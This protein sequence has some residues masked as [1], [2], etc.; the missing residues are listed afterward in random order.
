MALKKIFRGHLSPQ[1]NFLAEILSRK[2]LNSKKEHTLHASIC[3][4]ECLTMFALHYFGSKS[5]SE[6]SG[7]YKPEQEILNNATTL[8]MLKN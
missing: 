2:V 5:Q 3:S 6:G 4:C 8:T 1:V 7:S